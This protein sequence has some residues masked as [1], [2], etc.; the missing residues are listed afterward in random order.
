MY[1]L[2]ISFVGMYEAEISFVGM[3]EAEISFVEIS[4]EIYIFPLEKEKENEK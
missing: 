4:N 3:Y 2:V 1:E